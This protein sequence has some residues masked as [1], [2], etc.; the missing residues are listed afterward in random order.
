MADNILS[1]IVSWAEREDQ[2]TA[3]VL[4]GSRVEKR[5]VTPNDRNA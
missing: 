4:E 3:L 5:Q 1:G 2:V